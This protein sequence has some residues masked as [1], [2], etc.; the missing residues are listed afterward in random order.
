MKIDYDSFYDVAAVIKKFNPSANDKSIGEI[1]GI[2][3]NLAA[4]RKIKSGDAI[5][6]YGFVLFGLNCGEIYAAIVPYL[7]DKG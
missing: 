2:M 5:E 7:F 1:V 4:R 6:T 3:V